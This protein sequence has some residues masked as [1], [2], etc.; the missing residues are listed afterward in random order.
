MSC[1]DSMVVHNREK[2]SMHS[3]QVQNLLLSSTLMWEIHEGHICKPGAVSVNLLLFFDSRITGFQ[4]CS[5]LRF[6]SEVSQTFN[7]KAMC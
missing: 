1:N 3:L 5:V 7:V 4:Q 2:E 6:S